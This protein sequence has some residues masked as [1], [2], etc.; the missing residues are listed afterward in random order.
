MKILNISKAKNSL[1]PLLVVPVLFKGEFFFKNIDLFTDLQSQLIILKQLNIFYKYENKNLYINSKNIIIPDNYEISQE[2]KT[3]GIIYFMGALLKYKKKIKYNKPG[4][5]EIGKRKIDIHLDFFKKLNCDI[6]ETDKHY[7]IDSKN[8]NNEINLEYNF[9]K[10]SVGATIN[11]ILSSLHG[12]NKIK[13]YNVATDPY[14][15]D[16]INILK[17][18]G[19]NIFIN[20]NK[21]IIEI[22]KINTY[23]IVFK[24]IEHDAIQD[25]IIIGT[26]II[27]SIMFNKKYLIHIKNVDNLGIFLEYLIKIGI[28]FKKN[29]NDL[30]EF[31][32]K[33]KSINE[34]IIIN[35]REFPGF[36]TDLQPLFVSLCN[37]LSINVEIIE[38]IMDNR[39]LYLEELKKIGYK[40]KFL[41]KNHIKLLEYNKI[42]NIKEINFPDLRGGF[43]IFL[44]LKKNN[45]D[46]KK[47][48]INNYEV[49]LRGYN[50]KYINKIFFYK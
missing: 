31:Y 36:Y 23:N 39:F 50:I 27:L 38:N 24:K 37:H 47:I 26:Y 7:Q 1:L 40:Y 41:K 6:I 15:E 48:K 10:I 4:G 25:P 45:F 19:V 35:T 16:L 12:N 29:N 18:I 20:K 42:D 49:I 8:Y 34:K 32:I 9:R 14:I 3:R 30:Y 5:C 44:E 11:A 13:L 33:N 22:I 17:K 2:R 21:R 28:N 46:F 43:T